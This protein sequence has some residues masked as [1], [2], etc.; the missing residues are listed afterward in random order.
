MDGELASPGGEA[1]LA[2]KR[3]EMVEDADNGILHNI[4]TQLTALG[5]VQ[6]TQLSFAPLKVEVRRP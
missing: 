1:A 5:L 6:P 2:A 4:L 3:V